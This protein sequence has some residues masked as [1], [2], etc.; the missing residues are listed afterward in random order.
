MANIRF[1]NI[2]IA[3]GLAM[4]VVIEWHTLGEHGP[5][6]DGWAMPVFSLLW[7]CFTSNLLRLRMS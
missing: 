2:D 5:F 6:T 7:G 1:D 3:R 4:L